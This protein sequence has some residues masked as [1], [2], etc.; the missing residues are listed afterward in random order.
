MREGRSSFFG[1]IEIDGTR[2]LINDLIER[3][4]SL[5]VRGVSSGKSHQSLI[6]H[7]WRKWMA[8]CSDGIEIQGC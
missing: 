5:L 2:R 7:Y 6:I 8:K 3:V 1:D 4:A